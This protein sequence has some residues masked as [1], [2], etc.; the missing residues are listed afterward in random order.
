MTPTC[1][2]CEVEC[3]TPRAE[4]GETGAAVAAPDNIAP[5]PRVATAAV[6]S[7]SFRRFIFL[8]SFQ[9]SAPIPGIGI[10][11]GCQSCTGVNRADRSDPPKLRGEERSWCLRVASYYP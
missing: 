10:G 3:V 9:F 5:P 7:T 4:D 11:T 8:E 1:S 2:T 6:A